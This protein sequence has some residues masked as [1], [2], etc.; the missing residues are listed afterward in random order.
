MK[1]YYNIFSNYVFNLNVSHYHSHL[2]PLLT[3][4][5]SRSRIFTIIGTPPAP[6]CDVMVRHTLDLGIL[7]NTCRS[8]WLT[9]EG[10]G[11]VVGRASVKVKT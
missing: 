9:A 4:P 10:V 8:C 11:A 2:R 1:I 5:L 7:P 3:C 6:P